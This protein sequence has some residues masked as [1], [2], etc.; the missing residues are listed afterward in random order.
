MSTPPQV[1]PQ[2][3]PQV[4]LIPTVLS[5]DAL[6]ALPAYV[7]PA[8]LGCSALYVENERTAR[9][10]LKKLSRDIVIDDF[11][12]V[13]IHK[14]EEPVIREFSADLASGRVIGILSEAGCPGVADPGQLLVAA[15]QRA[16]AVVKPLV[17]PSS[18]LL[19]LMASGM[20][21]QLFRFN[22]YL[23]I[24]AA[25]R[26]KALKQLEAESQRTGSTEI[27][28]ETPYRN[29][30]LLETIVKHCQDQTRICVAAE[31]TGQGE[32]VWTKT[33]AEWKKD[34]PD[35]HKIPVLFL[36]SAG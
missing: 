7:L 32:S 22:G 27:F 36:L 6:D 17:G 8:V 34:M 5:E 14:A 9:R 10:Y 19:G 12:W 4:Y 23:P 11:K 15:A 13:A 3:A 28:I 24:D 31:L 21:G 20:N 30:A 29:N 26:Q 16:G 33:A 2:A 25:D 1:I 35:L 18:V